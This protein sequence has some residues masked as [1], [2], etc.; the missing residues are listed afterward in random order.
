[1]IDSPKRVLSATS[2]GV[3]VIAV[4][5]S[6]AMAGEDD[7]GSCTCTSP[8]CTTA[9]SCNYG[10]SCACCKFKAG[11]YACACCTTTFDCLN[12]PAGWFCDQTALW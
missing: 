2:L 3:A 5:A 1:M 7:E 8:L 11:T 12:L 4:F 9:A 10:E 6:I